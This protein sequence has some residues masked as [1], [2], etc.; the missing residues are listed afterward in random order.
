MFSILQLTIASLVHR[1]RRP[2]LEWLIRDCFLPASPSD[3]DTPAVALALS[4]SGKL[5]QIETLGDVLEYKEHLERTGEELPAGE[6]AAVLQ[7]A[8]A[9]QVED[10]KRLFCLFCLS[11][12]LRVVLR[13]LL[14]VGW[15]PSCALLATFTRLPSLCW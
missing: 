15:S 2:T 11:H 6:L 4:K 8:L 5:K 10:V 1:A 7:P 14:H 12:F 3:V 9:E 13:S